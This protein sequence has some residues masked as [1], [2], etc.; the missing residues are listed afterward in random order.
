MALWVCNN[1]GA[2]YSVGAPHC[3]EC[4]SEEFHEDGDV[5]WPGNSSPTF[6]EKPQTTLSGSDPSPEQPA[7]TTEN[8]SEK[9]PTGSDTAPSTDGATKAK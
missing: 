7:P 6:T 4:K 8:P 9:A 2:F 5:S 3:P 1:C